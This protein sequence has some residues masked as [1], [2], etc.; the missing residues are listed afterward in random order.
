MSCRCLAI[1]L[2]AVGWASVSGA[3]VG[4]ALVRFLGDF[5]LIFSSFLAGFAAQPILVVTVLQ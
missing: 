3:L 1:L 5:F 4:L 2:A